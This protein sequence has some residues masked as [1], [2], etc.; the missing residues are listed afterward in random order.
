MGTCTRVVLRAN[1][2]RALTGEVC[3]VICR[4]IISDGVHHAYLIAPFAGP[5][6]T[7]D[8]THYYN[9][10]LSITTMTTCAHKWLGPMETDG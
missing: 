4:P 9:A 8:H 10:L 2:P 6:N 7:G 3:I 5:G 1:F